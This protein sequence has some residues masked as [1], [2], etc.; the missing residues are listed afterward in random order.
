MREKHGPMLPEESRVDARRRTNWAGNV[1]FA[2]PD[3]LRPAT[4]AELQ[5]AIRRQLPSR[6]FS[7]APGW[8]EMCSKAAVQPSPAGDWA[9]KPT[10]TSSAGP[11][12]RAK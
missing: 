11:P 2:A 12:P 8:N 9:R 5:A 10:R 1:A 6:R 7:G 4:V 3:I